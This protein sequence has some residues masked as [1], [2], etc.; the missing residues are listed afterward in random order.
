MFTMASLKGLTGGDSILTMT[1]PDTDIPLYYLF[2]IIGA[3]IVVILA[4]II[5][6][7]KKE[8]KQYNFDIISECIKAL[9]DEREEIRV[10]S[11]WALNVHKSKEAEQSL[12][13]L[14]LDNSKFVR[15]A[16]SAA[17][18]SLKEES[19]ISALEEARNM[20]QDEYTKSQIDK[21]IRKIKGEEMSKHELAESLEEKGFVEVKLE[22]GFDK[23]SSIFS[24]ESKSQKGGL[25]SKGPK[26]PVPDIMSLAKESLPLKEN[27][28]K[29][30]T[31]KLQA[32][33][34]ERKSEE[35]KE[36]TVITRTLSPEGRKGKSCE[37]TFEIEPE[38][39]AS[40]ELLRKLEELNEGGVGFKVNLKFK[41]NE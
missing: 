36:K 8:G 30:V 22:S 29:E 35:V 32:E 27:K 39:E 12:M 6:L 13:R 7:K 41:W 33:K 11:C 10:R 34:E 2:I 20:E 40:T 19:S 18:G 31:K 23:A 38:T 16:A 4:I 37:I 28:D 14:L 1:L 5:I 21:A 17:L 15:G 25:F 3:L 9:N 26:K 24:G